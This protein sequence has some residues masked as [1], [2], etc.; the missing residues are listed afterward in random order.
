MGRPGGGGESAGTRR[1]T[2]ET[3]NCLGGGQDVH[4]HI[5]MESASGSEASKDF[6]LAFV[7]GLSQAGATT[8]RF[9][10]LSIL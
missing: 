10:E 2:L 9:W 3:G 5:E 7:L 6:A 8:C 4:N 1:A